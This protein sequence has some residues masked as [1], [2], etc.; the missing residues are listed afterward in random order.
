MFAGPAAAQL[1]GS[2]LGAAEALLDARLQLGE[3]VDL[4]SELERLVAS[5]PLRD[6]CT[7]S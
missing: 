4:V 5:D 3:H 6:T 1:E 7:R 2:R